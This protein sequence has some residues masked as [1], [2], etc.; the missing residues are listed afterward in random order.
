MN[1]AQTI[2]Q[3][4]DRLAAAFNRADA[5]AVSDLATNDVVSMPPNQPPILGLVA[6]R[7]WWKEGFRVAASHVDFSIQELN[8]VGDWAMGPY[9]WTMETRPTGG[10]ATGTDNGHGFWV[11]RRQADGSW[12]LALSIWN[13]DNPVP[14]TMW[15][16]AGRPGM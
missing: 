1:D 5:E 2:R 3:Q 8:V 14:G 11:W 16:G 12:K 6:A 10:G 13:S 4:A 9:T 7:S 15:S